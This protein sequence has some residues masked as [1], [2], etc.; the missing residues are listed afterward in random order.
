M[1]RMTIKRRLYISNILMLI[2]PVLLTFAVSGCVLLILMGV[3]GVRNLYT[4]HYGNLP[5]SIVKD[6]DIFAEKWAESDDIA[7]IKADID[8][9][10]SKY[11]GNGLLLAAYK[12]G[13]LLYPGEAENM[14]LPELALS[15]SGKYVIIDNDLSTYHASAG[16]YAVIALNKNLTLGGYEKDQEN[17]YIGIA[18]FAVMIIIV[19]FS[20]RILTRFVFR[21]VVTPID[22]LS[23]GVHEIRDGNLNYRIQYEN[24][25]EFSEICSDFNEMA[26]RLYDMVNARQKDESSRREL[27]AGIS[28]D[29]RTPLTSIKAYIEGL[30]KGVAAT[31]EKQKKYLDTIISKTGEMEYIIN[32]LFLFSKLDIGE[33][34]FRLEKVDIGNELDRMVSG[35][36]DEYKEKGLSVSLDKNVSGIY[37]TI[38]TVQFHNIIHNVLGNSL[39]YGKTGQAEAR[40]SCRE[41][42]GHVLIKIT[43]NGP[44]VPED[45]LEKLFDVFYRG[46]SSRKDTDKGSGLG[47]AITKKIVERFE[48]EISA[49]NDGN[50]GLSVIITLPKLDV[51]Q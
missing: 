5:L 31:P 4:L 42:G 34:P 3:S 6:I 32:Q 50:G 39:K 33:F 9:F 2:L 27:I 41:S 11:G 45:S 38:D 29:L 19:F 35:F 48:G 47:L 49:Q 15:G 24:N 28:H 21:S 17:F 37:V 40:L 44:G 30:E 25:D 13:E 16:D 20:N 10:N 43:D 23:G 18:A 8:E 26:V 36:A 46:D 7:V 12:N 51:R 14:L 1:F 22:I